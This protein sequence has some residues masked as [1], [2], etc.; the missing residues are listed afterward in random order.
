MRKMS[1]PT[2]AVFAGLG[3]IALSVAPSFAS[4]SHGTTSA[5]APIQLAHSSNQGQQSQG[6]MN[7]GQQGQQGQG[8]MNQ[9]QQGQGMM[10]QGQQGQ[11]MM[12]QGQQGQGMMNQ[13]QQGQGMMNQGQ[14]GQGMMGGMMNMMRQHMMGQGQGMMNRGTM[15]SNSGM[16]MGFGGQ[17]IVNKDLSTDD[18]SHF[19]GHRL[20]AQGNERLTLGD[21]TEVDENKITADINTVD[22]SLVQRLEIDRHSGMMQHMQQGN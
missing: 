1:K 11:G 20:E 6:M 3:A 16:G 7:P 17:V 5:E 15:G 13:G 21:V 10:N 14:Q 22:G 2:V 4:G 18:V 9:G 8:M 19:L 12:N